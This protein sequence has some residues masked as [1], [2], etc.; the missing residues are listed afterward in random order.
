[1]F[2]HCVIRS[3][4]DNAVFRGIQAVV[5]VEKHIESLAPVP[6]AGNA[7]KDVLVL[8]TVFLP[9]ISDGQLEDP[10]ID[11]VCDHLDWISRKKRLRDQVGKP[12][13]RCDN[14]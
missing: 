12:P 5:Q 8:K 13:G 4:K 9:K 11:A 10:K 2:I 3:D 6:G 14:R 1:M 7:Q